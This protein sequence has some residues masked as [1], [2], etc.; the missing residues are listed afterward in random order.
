MPIY[1]DHNATTFVDTRVVDSLLP[2][3]QAPLGNPS[4][5]HRY[6]RA[7]KD[8]L[9]AGRATVAQFVGVQPSQVIFTSG[10]TEANNLAVRGV[11]SRRP[12]GRVLISAI[13]HPSLW[14]LYAPLSREGWQVEWIPALPS[15]LIDLASLTEQLQQ[16]D[17]R[18]V[19]V[20]AANNETGVIQP[21]AEVGARC[22]QIGAAFHCDAVQAMGKIPLSFLE[23]K[24]TSLTLGAH[25]L[26]GPKGIGALILDRALDF[27][28]MCF[29]GG[30]ETGLRPGT[31]SVALVAGFAKACEL[32]MEECEARAAHTRALR[33]RLEVGLR[34]LP[35]VTV[36]GQ[37]QPRLPNT[38]QFS[39]PG[40]DGEAL[41]MALDRKG[42]AV[43]SGSA[44][45]SGKGEPSHVL[46][47]MGIE[48]VQ[49]KA[50]IRVSLGPMNQADE[51][52]RFLI[53][54]TGLMSRP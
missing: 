11:L 32:A 30:H 40:F 46:L 21:V 22:R 44:C 15:G 24:A 14:E 2:L 5:V 1:F 28:P 18:L 31:E 20:M 49:A 10:A 54:L 45:S 48:P 13:E 25:K 4:S 29:G 23:T 34:S 35:G 8:V 9:E 43:S 42:F 6:G 7:A 19:C 47:G 12:R 27:S 37:C 39:V 36:H 50:A 3:L 17:V 52:D 41:L 53:T 38:S 51:I 16:G 33:D 26:F